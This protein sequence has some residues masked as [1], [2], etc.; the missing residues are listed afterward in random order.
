MPNLVMCQSQ[1]STKFRDVDDLELWKIEIFAKFRDVQ[2]L[3]MYKFKGMH[4][5]KMSKDA[6]NSG[7]LKMYGY[8][9]LRNM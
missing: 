4:R 9:T 5:E 2:H 7:M 3:R 8:V 6:Q 1:A